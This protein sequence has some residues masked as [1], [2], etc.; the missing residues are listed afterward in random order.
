[1]C[2]CTYHHTENQHLVRP[3]LDDVTPP[4]TPSPPPRGPAPPPL[5]S[6]SSA[7]GSNPRSNRRQPRRRFVQSASLAGRS[8]Y[9]GSSGVATGRTGRRM[10]LRGSLNDDIKKSKEVV[11]ERPHTAPSHSSSASSTGG[12]SQ[13]QVCRLSRVFFV[14]YV[15]PF[16]LPVS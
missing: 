16:S 10:H 11:A 5:Q 9:A 4:L 2:V 13:H 12:A 1:M 14:F 7:K 3:D 8:P 15:H 6:G